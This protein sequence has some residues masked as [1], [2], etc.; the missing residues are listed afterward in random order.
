M[1]QDKARLADIVLACQEAMDYAQG[2]AFE[3]YQKDRKLQRALCMV[4][5]I[6]GEAARTVSEECKAANPQIPWRSIVGLRNRIIH[7]Y[8]R[9]DLK[10]IWDAVHTDIPALKALVEPLVPSEEGLR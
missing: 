1:W 7:E 4:L 6:I 2:V 8:F 9:L 3:D 5:E 10:V